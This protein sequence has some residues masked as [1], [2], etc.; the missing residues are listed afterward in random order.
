MRFEYSLRSLVPCDRVQ[1]LDPRCGWSVKRGNALGLP[2]DLAFCSINHKRSPSLK[3]PLIL[4]LGM[5]DGHTFQ[6]WG[7]AS[8]AFSGDGRR[9]RPAP[10]WLQR[11]S[12]QERAKQG[13]GSEF[14]I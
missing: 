3:Q 2:S 10:P 11:G 8:P 14:S 13:S 9:E 12:A 4:G 1:A 7:L 5:R 6:S